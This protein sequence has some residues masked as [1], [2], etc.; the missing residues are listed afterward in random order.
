M[1][2]GWG[3]GDG[4]AFGGMVGVWDGGESGILLHLTSV[5]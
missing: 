5:V 3:V 4:M 2:R 1:D